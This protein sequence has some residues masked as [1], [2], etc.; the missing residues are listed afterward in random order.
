MWAEMFSLA[1]MCMW[2]TYL[3]ANAEIDLRLHHY[4]SMK[5]SKNVKMINDSGAAIVWTS[6]REPNQDYLDTKLTFY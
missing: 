3:S 5:W 2:I 6:L 1:T 4:R